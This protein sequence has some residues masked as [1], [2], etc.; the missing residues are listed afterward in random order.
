M[1][2]LNYIAKIL[3]FQIF[4]AK[5][6]PSNLLSPCKMFTF[7]SLLVYIFRCKKIFDY[8]PYLFLDEI[9][10]HSAGH[11]TLRRRNHGLSAERRT[12]LQQWG[13]TTSSEHLS[14]SQGCDNTEGP[15]RHRVGRLRV[16]PRGPENQSFRDLR[17]ARATRSGEQSSDP[18]RSNRSK[19]SSL[20]H[21]LFPIVVIVTVV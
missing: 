6:S 7:E 5:P 4:C 12:D 10:H 17:G 11:I 19:L 15:G 2:I 18:D 14:H 20:S 13:D 9:S 16:N 1:T 8:F 21:T 3:L